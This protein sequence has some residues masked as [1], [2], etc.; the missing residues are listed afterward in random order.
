MQ[1]TVC[2]KSLRA[3][4]TRHGAIVSLVG[5]RP[6]RIS[7]RSPSILTPTSKA[8][9]VATNLRGGLEASKVRGEGRKAEFT[10]CRFLHSVNTIVHYTHN[11]RI[12][13]HA[14]HTRCKGWHKVYAEDKVV[15]LPLSA[16]LC[17][18]QAFLE[19]GG[20]LHYTARPLLVLI[21]HN[22]V[23]RLLSGQ[24]DAHSQASP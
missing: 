8:S 5:S 2:G 10:N 19:P 7:M 3:A 11:D 9:V 22:L 20:R 15:K 6:I 18:T 24:W 23:R 14:L 21:I 4:Q 17:C 16:H 12:D 13:P 1:E